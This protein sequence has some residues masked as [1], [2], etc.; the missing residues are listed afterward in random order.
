M[1]K[2]TEEII[3]EFG[4]KKVIVIGDFYLD[5]YLHCTA[6]RFSPEAPVPRALIHNVEHVPGC[7]SNVAMCFSSLGANVECVGIIGNDEKGG[8]LENAL[9]KKG[10]FTQG[11]LRDSNRITGTFSRILIEGKGSPKQ[12]FIRFDL[13]NK[14]KISAEAQEKCIEHLKQS[15]PGAGLLFVADY[16]ESFGTGLISGDFLEKITAL[17]RQNNVKV[18]GISRININTF[19]DFDIIVCNKGEIEKA[20]GIMVTNKETMKVAASKIL[21]SNNVKT[22][23]V[24][25][26]REGSIIFEKGKAEETEIPAYGDEVVDVCGAGDAYSSAYCLSA[27]SDAT[28]HEA[29]TIA[30]HTAGIAV[31]KPGTAAVSSDE[32]LTAISKGGLAE[33]AIL[34]R[35]NLK[36]ELDRLKSHGKKIVF[37]NGYFDFIHSGQI[38]FLRK[39]KS[40]GDVLIVAINSDRSTRENKGEG[41]PILNEAERI[42][43][44]TALQFVDFVTVFDETTP[45][46]LLSFLKPDV[47]TKGGNYTAEQVVGKNIVESHGGKV[48]LIPLCGTPSAEILKRLL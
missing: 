16:D 15:L 39:S 21:E 26:G 40:K 25:R 10:I 29:G 20:A 36:N 3:K 37:A 34:D 19:R 18:A 44:L 33:K 41:R 43:I 13:E 5:E 48:E 24:T 22:A 1:P 7:A 12:H 42:S 32:L 35:N 8:I 14:E 4:T 30:S 45:I 11:L 28:A 23:I 38:E 47:L 27:L 17:A 2:N 6:E 31:S 9:A 46:S